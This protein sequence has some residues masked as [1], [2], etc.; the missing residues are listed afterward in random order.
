MDFMKK[1]LSVL[2]IVSMIFSV[3]ITSYSA[4]RDAHQPDV[5][6]NGEMINFPDQQT[7]IADGRTLVPVRGFFEHL[8]CKVEWDEETQLVTLTDE[9]GSFYIFM[10]IGYPG[11]VVYDGEDEYTGQLDVVPQIINSRTMVPMSFIRYR[12]MNGNV[13][14]IL[15]GYED[16]TFIK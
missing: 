7:Q 6:L 15:F 11:L 13:K 9:N 4:N 5:Y 8:G 3:G 16:C 12:N 2:L 14:P 1:L 10:V